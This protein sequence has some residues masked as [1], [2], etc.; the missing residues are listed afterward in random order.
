MELNA[1][2]VT[3]LRVIS[4]QDKQGVG[5][6]ASILK[7][8]GSEIQQLLTEL[9]MQVLG[10]YSAAHIKEGLEL[11]WTPSPGMSQYP[12]FAPA[13]SGAY[14]NYRKTTIYGGSNEIQRNIISKMML[15][16]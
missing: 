9:Q 4:A 11:D 8:K 14:F 3:N 15:D 2:E 13:L 16:L 7:I 12:E 6:Q 5:A 10:P 1:L